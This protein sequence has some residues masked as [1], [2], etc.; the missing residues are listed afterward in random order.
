MDEI[1]NNLFEFNR[2]VYA[3]DEFDVDGNLVY[4]HPLLNEVRLDEPD[5]RDQLDR[6]C[7]QRAI[8]KEREQ[9]KRFAFLLLYLFQN[10]LLMML[11]LHLLWECL[12]LMMMILMTTHLLHHIKRENSMHLMEI[13]VVILMVILQMISIL[14]V[15]VIMMI[16]MTQLNI[17]VQDVQGEIKREGPPDN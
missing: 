6:L 5:R 16:N 1:C 12:I 13:L 4:H 8:T 17:S 7:C 10:L 9:S 15:M 2:D 14:V 11:R 3:K